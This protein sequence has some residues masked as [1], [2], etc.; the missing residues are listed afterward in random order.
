MEKLKGRRLMQDNISRVHLDGARLKGIISKLASAVSTLDEIIVFGSRARGD[1]RPDSDI[2]LYL[3]VEDEGPSGWDVM[4]D[5]NAALWELDLDWDVVSR[6]RSEYER[7]S[8]DVAAVE[9]AVSREGVRV[10]G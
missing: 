4:A 5:A 2:D 10:Y 7:L 1:N 9:Y 3:V 8:D 6:K